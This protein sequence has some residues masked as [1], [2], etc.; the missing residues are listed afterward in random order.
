MSRFPLGLM[1]RSFELGQIEQL[2]VYP[3]I[4]RLKPRWRRSADSG[5]AV[6]DLARGQAGANDD[7]FHRLREYRPGDN[8]RA[9]HW[10]TTARRSQ[11][12]V[13]EYQ[14][15]RRQDLLLVVD[16]W[17]PARAQRDDLERVEMAVSFAA[18]ICV[19][20]MQA[21]VDSGVDLVICGRETRRMSGPAG[22]RSI[23]GL[24]EELAVAEAGPASGLSAVLHETTRPHLR[25]VL[26]TTRPSELLHSA[27]VAGAQLQKSQPQE[28]DPRESQALGDFEV[29]AADLPNVMEYLE[30][31]DRPD[32]APIHPHGGPA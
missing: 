16:L 31:E 11:L 4:G 7:E 29:I 18:S 3:R 26:L 14:H 24:L 17:L 23:G 5:E 8:P 15:N 2:I 30:F 9:I 20:Q 27:I 28:S 10:R 32:P 19:D 25:R 6:S 12:M 13:R 21:A 22:S 1:E